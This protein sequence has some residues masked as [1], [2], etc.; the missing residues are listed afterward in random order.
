M[1]SEEKK[2]YNLIICHIFKKSQ[3]LKNLSG[4]LNVKN[5]YFYLISK[6][7][8]KFYLLFQKY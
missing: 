7:K 4:L 3:C 2:H 6:N 8:E 1:V 5:N